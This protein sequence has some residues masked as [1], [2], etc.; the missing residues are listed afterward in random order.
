MTRRA[1]LLHSYPLARGLLP[2][3]LALLLAPLLHGHGKGEHMGRALPRR[4]Q[5]GQLP[6]LTPVAPATAGP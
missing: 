5:L 2:L 3:L 4:Q 1:G 6:Q